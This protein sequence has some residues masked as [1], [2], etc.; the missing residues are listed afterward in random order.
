MREGIQLLKFKYCMPSSASHNGRD[1]IG[2]HQDYIGY[3]DDLFLTFGNSTDLRRALKLLDEVFESFSLAIGKTKTK[4]IFRRKLSQLH[5]IPI[6]NVEKLIYLGSCIKSDEPGTGK[7]EVELR[8]DLAKSALY[9]LS[10]IFFHK[11]I[12]IEAR[13]QIMNSIVRSRIIFG[14]Q[15]WSQQLL[16]KISAIYI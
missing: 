13:V 15:T 3:A 14:C 11:R 6:K 16:S 9:H 10:G 8:I 5:G 12:A 1:K 4:T 7:T 2:R